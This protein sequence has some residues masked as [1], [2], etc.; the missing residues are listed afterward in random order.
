M[1][2]FS[3]SY[4]DICKKGI[5]E[6]NAGNLEKASELFMRAME[7]DSSQPRAFYWLGLTYAEAMPWEGPERTEYAQLAI[8]AFD[9]GIPRETDAECKAF[10][11][12]QRGL[13]F[14]RLG[15]QDEADASYREADNV[16]PGFTK[17]AT[18]EMYKT[19]DEAMKRQAERK[20][21]QE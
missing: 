8:K 2:F 13:M 9:E 16:I 6:F 3:P 19:L 17:K 14:H 15:R 4:H 11:W 5:R 12:Q 7:M 18:E 1:G 20:T 21:G 10:M